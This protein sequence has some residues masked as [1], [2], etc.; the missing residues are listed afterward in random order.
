M[1]KTIVKNTLIELQ[2]NIINELQEQV[3]TVHTMVDIDE[4]MTHDPEDYSHQYESKEIEE[5]VKIQLNRAKI[6][7][8]HLKSIDFDAKDSVC[9]GAVVFTDKM[10][11]FIGFATVPFDIDEHH[12][13]GIS[14]GSPIYPMMAEKKV[15]D[16]F[17]FSGRDYKIEAIY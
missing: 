5:M 15:G 16:K 6:G 14:L 2:E 9:S 11:F 13:V 12:I 10:K 4:E 7:L 17:S 8:D 3:E 1:D